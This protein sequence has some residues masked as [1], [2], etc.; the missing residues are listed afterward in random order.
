MPQRT[1]KACPA[2]G[3]PRARFHSAIGIFEALAVR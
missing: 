3:L 1:A 2:Q